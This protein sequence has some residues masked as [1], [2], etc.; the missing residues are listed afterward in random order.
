MKLFRFGVLSSWVGVWALLSLT[1]AAQSGPVIWQ[2]L[3]DKNSSL[4]EVFQQNDV[5]VADAEPTVDNGCV[6][7]ITSSRPYIARFDEVGNLKWA[8]EYE[9]GIPL[10]QIAETS[11]GDFIG[12]GIINDN[13]LFAFVVAEITPSGILKS[14]RR[15]PFLN[16]SNIQ[17]IDFLPNLLPT[18]DGGFL[19]G[20]TD[21]FIADPNI[22][23]RYHKV[24]LL[25]INKDAEIQWQKTI[26]A[27]KQTILRGLMQAET[28]G[29]VVSLFTNSPDVLGYD[30][31]DVISN[32]GVLLNE[33]GNIAQSGV[34]APGAALRTTNGNFVD[35]KAAPP[36]PH[37]FTVNWYN[38]NMDLLTS[39]LLTFSFFQWGIGAAFYPTPDG[40]VL[41]GDP[42][43]DSSFQPDFRLTKYSK[44]MKQEWQQIGGG[45]GEDII[46]A[47]RIAADGNYLIFGRTN[48]PDNSF[49]GINN[50]P[51]AKTIWIRKQTADSPIDNG[52]SACF[53]AEN[54]VGTGNIYGD[55]NASGGQVRREYG[56]AFEYLVYNVT[57]IP[58]SGTYIFQLR[59]RNEES[60]TAGIIVNGGAVQ[61]ITLPKTGSGYAEAGMNIALNAGSNTI[62][63]QGGQGGAFIQDRI[64]IVKE[65]GSSARAA[66]A[67]P[68]LTPETGD[69]QLMVYPN[70][71]DGQFITRFYAAK[72]SEMTLKVTDMTG[73]IL[74]ERRVVGRGEYCE[75]RFTW[76][77]AVSGKVIVTLQ[78]GTQRVTRSILIK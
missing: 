47:V 11:D 23:L 32:F 58:A 77:P 36:S 2:R 28:G 71:N 9:I 41:V 27:T 44:D 59:F 20:C 4:P 7:A 3:L 54:A 57:G 33:Q 14:L 38:A 61:T 5:S 76:T 63:V 48:S 21:E 37:M 26:G 12:A 35:V 73:R 72:N 10:R 15:V 70:P 40:G 13:N 34:K 56:N 69:L 45:G 66:T 6:L 29:Y 68:I 30:P 51:G 31:G 74:T 46:H 24:H 17:Y 65:S 75:E 16:Q 22:G 42:Y 8:K 52:F 25:K 67:E 53:E 55:N 60:P 43:M 64:C 50:N 19:M 49:F 62:R 1:A 18:A 78:Q 39:R